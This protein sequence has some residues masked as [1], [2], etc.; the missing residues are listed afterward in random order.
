MRQ[1]VRPP[2][3]Y[4]VAGARIGG[5]QAP[6]LKFH[7]SYL[8]VVPALRRKGWAQE[9][10]FVGQLL[11]GIGL[12]LLGWRVSSDG[13]VGPPI[14]TFSSCAVPLTVSAAGTA[15]ASGTATAVCGHRG[16]T[17]LCSW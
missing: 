7:R 13:E 8:V 4:V 11:A 5:R 15:A 2:H 16:S 1:W 14:A 9:P 6:G 12:D 3:A 10:G 17:A